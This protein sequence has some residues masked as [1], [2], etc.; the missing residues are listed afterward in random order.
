MENEAVPSKLP[1]K[2]PLALTPAGIITEPLAAFKWISPGVLIFKLLGLTGDVATGVMSI[3]A[4]KS[5]SLVGV[6]EPPEPPSTKPNFTSFINSRVSSEVVNRGG[7]PPISFPGINSIV[8]C[9]EPVTSPLYT[10][11]PPLLLRAPSKFISPNWLVLP[12]IIRLPEIPAE[13][14]NGNPLPSAFR[15]NEAVVANEALNASAA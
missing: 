3:P 11:S 14:V 4:P 6:P 1:V 9:D 12:V 2:P 5:V 8:L 15:A 13:P 10:L 7:V